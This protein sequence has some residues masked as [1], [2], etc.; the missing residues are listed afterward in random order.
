MHKINEN[1]LMMMMIDKFFEF[2]MKIFE[3]QMKIFEPIL[4]AK[5]YLNGKTAQPI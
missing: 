3:F 1:I 4:K 5:N 2:Q